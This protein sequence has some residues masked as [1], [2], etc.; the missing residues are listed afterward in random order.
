MDYE[1]AKRKVLWA[2]SH[3]DGN[4]VIAAELY[5]DDALLG[6]LES[7]V[8]FRGRDNFTAGRAEYPSEV[9]SGLRSL[10]GERDLWVC[11]GLGRLRRW[12]RYALRF[13][14]QYRGDASSANHLSRSVFRRTR[15]ERP[16]QRI[17]S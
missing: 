3:G 4:P 1:G 6:F 16:T 15:R 14:Q 17:P 13:V 9:E 10:R 11:E 7:G 12:R 5:H 8:R 2:W